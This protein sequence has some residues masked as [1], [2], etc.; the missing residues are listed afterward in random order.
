MTEQFLTISVLVDQTPQAVFDAVANVRGWWTGEIDGDADQLGGVFSYRYKDAHRSA[1]TI[2]AF[3]P[4]RRVVWHVDDA[5]LNF[6]ENKS[7]WIG[8]NIVFDIARK[9]DKTEL[10]FTHRGLTPACECYAGCSGA[11][12]FFVGENLKTLIATGQPAARAMAS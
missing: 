3:E 10:V 11:W 6:V 4:G 8:T 7:E 9:G 12:G 2:T 5:Q 1:Q